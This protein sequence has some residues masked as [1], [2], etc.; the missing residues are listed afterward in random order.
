MKQLFHPK[1]DI[2][3]FW[4]LSPVSLQIPKTLQNIFEAL[5]LTPQKYKDLWKNRCLL[6]EGFAESFHQHKNRDWSVGKEGQNHIDEKESTHLFVLKDLQDEDFFCDI[7]LYFYQVT[8][9]FITLNLYWNQ[10]TASFFPPHYDCH[11]VFVF[12][13]FGKKNWYIAPPTHEYPT[14][15]LLDNA[16]NQYPMKKCTQKDTGLYIPWGSWHHA[17]PEE[18]SIHLS[19]GIHDHPFFPTKMNT[20]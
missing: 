7:A 11:D 19:I 16:P 14:E 17:Q 15:L 6:G 5:D 13:I 1:D 20:N 9:G 4:H 12:Q 8:G 3:S 2:R 10:T 18:H